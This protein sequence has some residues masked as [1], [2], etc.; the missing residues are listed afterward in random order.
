MLDINKL[1]HYKAT[2]DGEDCGMVV[3]SIVDEPAIEVPFF[4]FAKQDMLFKIQDE[5]QRMVL[6]P[7]MIPGLAIY[8]RDESGY[9][10]TIEYDAETI[11]QMAEKYFAEGRVN[12][13]DK[14]HSFELED[15]ITLVQAFYKNIEKGINPK[16]FEELP[17]DTLFFQYH[18]LNDTVW[19]EIKEGKYSGFSLAGTF[20]VKPV[21]MKKE[22]PNELDE[23][24]SMIEKIKTKISK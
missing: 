19:E 15:G 7:V 20:N 5:E 16:G 2:L 12:D 6:G 8:R 9:E 13:V 24:L 11:H 17:N 14:Q 3:V 23:I 1:P 21:E 22:T 18:V 4:A 10:Y